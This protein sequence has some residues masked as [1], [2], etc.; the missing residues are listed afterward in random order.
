MS[1]SNAKKKPNG[2]FSQE[3]SEGTSTIISINGRND[4]STEGSI[5]PIFQ[6]TRGSHQGQLFLLN[7]NRKVTM[8]RGKDADIRLL[9]PG[10]SRKHIELFKTS[11]GVC[12]VKDLKSTNGTNI[13]GEKILGVHQLEDGDRIQIGEETTMIFAFVPKSEAEARLDVYDQATKDVLTGAYNRRHFFEILQRE[14]PSMRRKSQD[15]SLGVII[16]DIDHFKKVNDT[17]GHIA[18]DLVLKEI[19]LIVQGLI[20]NEDVFARYGGE[21]FVILT[22][23]EELTGIKILAERIRATIEKKTLIYENKEI[24]VT[25]SAGINILEAPKTIDP[26]DF[27]D[28][29]D[30]ALY[31][32]KKTGRNKV[33]IS[34]YLRKP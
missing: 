11:D 14:I 22:R 25:I 28:R 19:S 21:E 16:F 27:L 34:Q 24:K 7:N 17:F 8:G 15:N 29:A 13:N 20:R 1:S 31:N 26:I 10:C 6:I 2:E 5:I 12:F 18:G 4:L 30:K 33:L 32:A 3:T 23:N 9:D